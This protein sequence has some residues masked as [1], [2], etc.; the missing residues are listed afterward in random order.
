MIN[1]FILT[2]DFLCSTKFIGEFMLLVLNGYLTHTR[3]YVML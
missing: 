1:I 2:S 3:I